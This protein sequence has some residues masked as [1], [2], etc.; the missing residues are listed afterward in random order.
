VGRT[1]IA[2][3]RKIWYDS[4]TPTKG[5]RKLISRL[6]NKYTLVVFSGNIR[7]RVKYLDKKYGIYN[8]FDDFVMSYQYGYNKPEKGFY[9]ALIKRIK[10]KPEECVLIDDR[11]ESIDIA[12]SF[13]MNGLLFKNSE[14]LIKDLKSYGV[15]F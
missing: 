5:M 6:K 10:C 11:K 4:Y 12:K 15:V 2:K 7:E 9:K 3:I 1:Q 13:G 8:K 14:K